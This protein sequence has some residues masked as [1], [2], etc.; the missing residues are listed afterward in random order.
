MNRS[1]D[2]TLGNSLKALWSGRTVAAFAILALS[3]MTFAAG[4][5]GAGCFVPGAKAP[6]AAKAPFVSPKASDDDKWEPA[7][8]VGLWQTH[9]YIGKESANVTFVQSLKTWHGDHTE[10]EEAML[11]PAGGNVCFGVWKEVGPRT[12][13]LHHIGWSF[14]PDGSFAGGFTEVETDCVAEDGKTYTGT[15]VFTPFNADGVAIEGQQV[16]GVVVATRFPVD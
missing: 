11:P 1:F 6:A 13:K 3:A 2:M 10:M 9:Y 16:T 7:T 14:N 12:V 8:I 4:G 15:Y 5:A